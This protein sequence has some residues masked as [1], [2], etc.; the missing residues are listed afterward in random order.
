MS[1]YDH[2]IETSLEGIEH[3]SKE[4]KEDLAEDNKEVLEG[5]T[6]VLCLKS[7]PGTQSGNAA[8]Q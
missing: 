4:K 7:H 3:L 1:R 5:W 2:K 8:R 6:G